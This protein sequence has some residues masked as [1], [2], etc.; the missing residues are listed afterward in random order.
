MRFPGARL[1]LIILFSTAA[2]S[3]GPFPAIQAENL[4]GKKIEL[5]G[6]VS[7]HPT[8][9]IIGFT[10]ASQAQTK[11]WAT[12]LENEFNPYSIAV[13]QDA[14]RLVRGMAVR[15]IKGEVPQSRRDRFLLLFHGEKELKQA[16]EFDRP[17]DAYLLLV[18]PGGLIQARWHGPV[19]DSAVEDI[20]SRIAGLQN[21]SSQH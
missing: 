13:L 7:Q 10:H 17:D 3:A 6:T 1:G 9:F 2:Y 21:S 4:E 16:A 12:R 8:L 20:R 15:G 5:P 18:D 11:P 14:P 19:S